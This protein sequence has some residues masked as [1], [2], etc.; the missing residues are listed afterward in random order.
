[1]VVVV[2]VRVVAIIVDVEVDVVACRC[3]QPKTYRKCARDH[4]GALI[5]QLK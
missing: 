5:N 4:D 1:M 3:E 2:V